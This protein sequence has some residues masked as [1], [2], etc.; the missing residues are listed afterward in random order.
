M[1]GVEQW[2][3]LGD[4]ATSQSEAGAPPSGANS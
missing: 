1:V 4:L 2:A 3:A